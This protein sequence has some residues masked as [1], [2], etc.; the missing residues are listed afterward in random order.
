M[1]ANLALAK[2]LRVNRRTLMNHPFS[3]F[4]YPDD[5]NVY[6]RHRLEIIETHPRDVCQLRLLP[7]D[8]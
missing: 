5:Q 2:K 8:A 3:A 1:E 6:Y 4:I 7:R